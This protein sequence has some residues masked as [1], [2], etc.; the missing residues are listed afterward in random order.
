MKRPKRLLSGLLK[1]AACGAGI[2]VKGKDSTGRVRI[3]CSAHAESRTCSDPHTFYLD[4]VEDLVLDTLRAELKSPRRLVVYVQAY[5]EAPQQYAQTTAKR[6]SELERRISDLDAEIDRMVR[7]IRQGLG[8]PERIGREMQAAEAE[9]LSLKEELASEPAP[10]DPVVLHP[11]AIQRYEQQ[12][13]RLREELEEDL[14]SGDTKAAEVMRELIESITVSR[15]PKTGKG[16][17]IEIKGKLRRLIEAPALRS[18]LGGAMVAEEGFEPPT[19][20]L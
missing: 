16:V 12:L 11:F 20:G 9:L 13:G 3:Q 1:C 4:V 15:N 19:Q 5:N 7:F 18:A 8:N 10:F 14:A 2:S 6:R 17:S